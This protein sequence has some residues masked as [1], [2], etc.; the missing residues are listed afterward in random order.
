[1]RRTTTTGSRSHAPPSAAPELGTSS[2]LAPHSS[3]HLDQASC[4]RIEPPAGPVAAMVGRI[5]TWGLV[6]TA[7]ALGT[8]LSAFRQRSNFYSAAVYLSK[9]NACMMVRPP[10]SPRRG[11]VPL[12]R[13]AA[14][15]PL[16]RAQILWNQALFHTVLFGK[17]LQAI[18]FGELRLV[19]VEVRTAPLSA[20]PYPR[21]ELTSP[22]ALQR[23]QERGW[24]AITETLLALTIFRDDFDCSFVVL[25]ISLL[26]LKVFHWLAADRVEAVRPVT[27]LPKPVG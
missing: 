27:P 4:T 2:L 16:S 24:F 25:F 13:A 8:V 10:S 23:L 15:A 20:S 19:E 7:L 5:A 6:S 11:L 12:A 21:R 17:A 3:P 18:F 1:M 14:H 9:S 22:S 26:F